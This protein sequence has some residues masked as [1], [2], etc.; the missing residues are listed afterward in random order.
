MPLWQLLS[1]TDSPKLVILPEVDVWHKQ[2]KVCAL[3]LTC[4]SIFPGQAWQGL[5]HQRRPRR[6]AG[7]R[8]LLSKSAPPAPRATTALQNS[9]CFNCFVSLWSASLHLGTV[10]LTACVPHAAAPC[11]ALLWQLIHR[12]LPSSLDP[13]LRASG[14]EIFS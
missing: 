6:G 8:S 10:N 12:C 2:G 5:A 14:K 13:F 9:L 11:T 1:S 3:R 4:A 7:R